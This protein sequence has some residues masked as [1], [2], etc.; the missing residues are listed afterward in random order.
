MRVFKYNGAGI[1]LLQLSSETMQSANDEVKVTDISIPSNEHRT[2]RIYP[3]GKAPD[4]LALKQVAMT[5]SAT[6][7]NYGQTAQLTLTGY[8]E[9]GT[10]VN[11]SGAA[12][13]YSSTDNSII[14][15]S[16][17]GL[18]RHVSLGGTRQVVRASVTLG[19][20]TVASNGLTIFTAK[21]VV[22]VASTS[23]TGTPAL[24]HD[25]I[26]DSY[27][28]YSKADTAPAHYI[29]YDLGSKK[30]VSRVRYNYNLLNFRNI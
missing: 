23:N 7:L 28:K 20:R 1:P 8:A 17:T 22:P 10:T 27:W 14:S 2:I 26:L 16:G 12:I 6:F 15:V 18:V 21:K 19:G 4:P 11:L 13:T 30:A 24:A 3:D 25:G 5:S 9:N 29:Q